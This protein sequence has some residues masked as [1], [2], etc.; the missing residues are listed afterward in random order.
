MGLRDVEHPSEE[1]PPPYHLSLSLSHRLWPRHSFFHSFIHSVLLPLI[2]P[3]LISPSNRQQYNWNAALSPVLLFPDRNALFE[4][5]SSVVCDHTQSTD[6]ELWTH[7][8]GAAAALPWEHM[9]CSKELPLLPFFQLEFRS[10]VQSFG[11]QSMAAHP[12]PCSIRMIWHKVPVM[13]D[14]WCVVRPHLIGKRI[15]QAPASALLAR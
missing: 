4:F 3:S 11:Q 14:V 1:S 13:S 6:S 7:K 12:L 5:Y 15:G 8:C 2:I 10:Q 9:L